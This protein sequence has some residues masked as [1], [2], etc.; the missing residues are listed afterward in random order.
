MLGFVLM[1]AVLGSVIR[2]DSTLH[3]TEQ[4]RS[5]AMLSPFSTVDF[6]KI[7]MN[8]PEEKT[9]IAKRVFMGG[10][11]QKHKY[12]PFENLSFRE[13]YVEV[14]W[15]GAQSKY[16]MAD[17]LQAVDSREFSKIINTV[18]DTIVFTNIEGQPVITDVEKMKSEI[19]E[20]HITKRMFF[21]GTDMFGRDLLSRLMAGSA[22]SLLVGFIGVFAALIIGVVVGLLAGYFGGLIDRML[23]ALIALFWSIP[24]MLMVVCISIALG[25][26]IMALILSIGLVLWVEMAQVVRQQVQAIKAKDFVKASKLIGLSDFVILKRHILPNVMSPIAVIAA[27]T[28]ADALMIEAGLSFLG[29]GVMPPQPSWGNMIRESYGYLISGESIHMALAPSFALIF[30]ILSVILVAG[31]MRHRNLPFMKMRGFR[32]V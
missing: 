9:S 28:F 13:N 7:R 21:L 24:A 15:K 29:I 27:S 31:G 11:P 2:P 12:I 20:G 30:V 25:A 4:N 8:Y 14:V 16:F 26:G 3:A 6:L 23:K 32:S 18:S 1:V 10:S 17:V 22:V 5:L 19:L